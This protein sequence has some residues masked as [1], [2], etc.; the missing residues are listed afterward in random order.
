MAQKITAMLREKGVDGFT[1][2]TDA[3]QMDR[4][5]V[6]A[7]GDA[8]AAG[9]TGIRFQYIPEFDDAYDAARHA[10]IV[11]GKED[12]FYDIMN[13]ILSVEGV[14]Q[15]DVVHY[16]TKVF[17]RATGTDWMKGGETYDDFLGAAPGQGDRKARRG[18]PRGR[19]TT[20]PDSSP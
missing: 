6:Q 10:E 15:A 2:V 8:A 9:L 4:V 17:R 18:Q 14:A 13:D 7:A 16:D 19:G 11:A 12:L 3:R 20:P 1:F 5:D